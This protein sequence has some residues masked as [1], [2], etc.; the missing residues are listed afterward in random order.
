MVVDEIEFALNNEEYILKNSHYIKDNLF[1]IFIELP[2]G[3][4][5]DN[6]V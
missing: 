6:K 1:H 4:K 2:G 3:C 5:M